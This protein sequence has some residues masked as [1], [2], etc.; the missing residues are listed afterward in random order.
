[1]RQRDQIESMLC[2]LNTEFAADDVV[3]GGAIDE[4]RNGETTDRD[5][6]TR[7]QNFDLFIH[8]GRAIA[9]FIRRRNTSTAAW[10]CPGKTPA[11]RSEINCRSNGSFGECSELHEP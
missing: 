6:E 1:M 3:Q 5:Y 4:P 9:N 7:S 2:A 8:P 11:H 10:S